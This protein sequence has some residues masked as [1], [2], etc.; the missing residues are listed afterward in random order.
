MTIDPKSKRPAAATSADSHPGPSAPAL[1]TSSR[2][3]RLLRIA[4]VL[5]LVGLKKATIY[6][7]HQKGEFPR[8]VKITKRAVGWVEEEVQRWIA[9]RRDRR[10]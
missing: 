6:Q 5:E 4:Q 1:N 8:S 7:L 9:E 3:V 2:P 10:S